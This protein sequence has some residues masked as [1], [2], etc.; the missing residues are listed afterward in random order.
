MR[1]SGGSIRACCNL[2]GLSAVSRYAL[3]AQLPACFRPNEPEIRDS[4]I[5]GTGV[6]LFHLLISS[7]MISFGSIEIR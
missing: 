6:C 4:Q 2:A 3:P 1:T 5:R 7:D